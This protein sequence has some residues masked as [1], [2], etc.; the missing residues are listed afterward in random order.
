M[1]TWNRRRYLKG[2][3]TCS[4]QGTVERC[5]CPCGR[6]TIEQILYD[7]EKLTD[8]L[9]FRMNLC[10]AERRGHTESALTQI[11]MLLT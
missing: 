10:R 5:S 11:D 8:D 3:A 7:Y 2:A 4:W 1:K 9:G 6:D